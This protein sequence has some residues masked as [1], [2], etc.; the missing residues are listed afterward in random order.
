MVPENRRQIRL[1][2]AG[3]SNIDQR[4]L[5]FKDQDSSAPSKPA[6]TV[7][8]LARYTSV[9]PSKRIMIGSSAKPMSAQS[10]QGDD[11]DA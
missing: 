5:K 4:N 10:D 7:D 11:W 2:F 6:G 1:G 9:C 3:Q 8:D